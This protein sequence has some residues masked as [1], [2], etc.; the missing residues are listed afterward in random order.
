MKEL[1]LNTERNQE[2]IHLVKLL[3]NKYGNKVELVLDLYLI[4]NE[5]WIK[6]V[7]LYVKPKFRGEGL[8][9][10]VMK[11]LVDY[12]DSHLYKMMLE[13]SDL[14]GSDPY[15]LIDFY[16]R[17]GFIYINNFQMIR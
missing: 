6:L 9:K 11:D 4:N 13:V 8:G 3:E 14:F 17:F 5:F 15:K 2:L 12:A 7:S 10:L 16:S 1:I